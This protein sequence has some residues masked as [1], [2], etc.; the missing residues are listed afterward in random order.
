MLMKDH[1]SYKATCVYLW[2][3]SYN[4]GFIVDAGFPKLLW[5]LYAIRTDG[6]VGLMGPN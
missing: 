5:P 4:T 3:E 1:L 6:L 2:G